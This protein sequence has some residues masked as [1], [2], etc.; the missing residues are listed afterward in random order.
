MKMSN[1][2]YSWD[3]QT[4]PSGLSQWA[5]CTEMQNLL[6]ISNK[7]VRKNSGSAWGRSNTRQRSA[8]RTGRGC[9]N[10]P[11]TSP[12]EDATSPVFSQHQRDFISLCALSSYITLLWHVKMFNFLTYTLGCP[13][14]LLL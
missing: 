10:P 5:S 3:L 9:G 11:G 6:R 4:F 7:G 1:K 12:G 13:V 14:A 2:S 8:A